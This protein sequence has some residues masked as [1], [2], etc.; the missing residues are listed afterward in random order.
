VSVKLLIDEDLSPAIAQ[1]LCADG[2]DACHVRDRDMLGAKDHGV[3]DKAFEEDRI[4]VTANVDDFVR[5]A[6]KRDLHA[7]IVLIENG[8]LYRD[9]QLAGRVRNFVY[10]VKWAT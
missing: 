9:E 4:L 7:G 5:L 8:S 6:R 2:I 3:L 10:G 1:A